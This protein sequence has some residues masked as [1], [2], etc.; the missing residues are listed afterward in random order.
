VYA[1]VLRGAKAL[2]KPHGVDEPVPEVKEIE[3][4]ITMIDYQDFQ[5]IRVVNSS[6][7][8]APDGWRWVPLVQ[9]QNESALSEMIGEAL[10][11]A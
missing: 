2:A 4:F 6:S 10:L 7:G 1:I 11:C 3:D 5:G 8:A 9:L